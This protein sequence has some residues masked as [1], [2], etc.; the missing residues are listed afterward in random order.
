MVNI[1]R[2]AGVDEA[3]RG[4]LAGP[5]VSAAVVLGPD[6]KIEGLTDSKKLN[7]ATRERLATEI[8]KRCVCW[9]IGSSSVEEIDRLNILQSTMLSM[10]RAIESLSIRPSKVLIDGNRIPLVNIP[11][12]AIVKGDLHVSVISAASVLAKVTR[13]TIMFEYAAEYPEYGFEK[14]VG[15][16]TS[17]HLESLRNYGA[18]PIHRATFSPVRKAMD[19]RG[20][21]N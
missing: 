14:H 20:Q 8:K 3:G 19:S 15:Y 9:S 18:T 16:G 7:R 10:K 5:V 11:A 2:T 6:T 12:Q 21:L 17:L 13:D 1:E 4:A